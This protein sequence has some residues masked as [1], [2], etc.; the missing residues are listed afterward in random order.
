MHG[1]IFKSTRHECSVFVNLRPLLLRI[2]SRHQFSS[3]EK[4]TLGICILFVNPFTSFNT[5][6][7]LSFSSVPIHYDAEIECAVVDMM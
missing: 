4:N 5:N 7:Y 6:E 3:P 2:R 1:V